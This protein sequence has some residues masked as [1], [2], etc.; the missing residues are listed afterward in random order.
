MIELFQF[1]L[2][3]AQLALFSRQTR[4]GS[5]THNGLLTVYSRKNRNTDI[6]F[7][8][9]YYLCN[10]TILRFSLLGYIH[11]ADNFNSGSNG[12]QQSRTVGHL[13]IKGTVNTIT[14]TNLILHRLDVN[15]ARSLSYSLLNHCLDQLYNRRAVDIVV[16][17]IVLIC[18]ELKFLLLCIHISGI[19]NICRTVISINT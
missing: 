11:T 7:L 13:F 15:I 4:L 10:T 14:D 19:L 3:K 5:Q 2:I 12:S 6:K 9:V 1:F 17:D 8:S 16:V 18:L